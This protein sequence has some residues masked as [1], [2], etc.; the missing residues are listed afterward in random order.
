MLI[1][2]E[3]EMNITH[4]NIKYYLEKGYNCII[5]EKI[6]INIEDLNPNSHYQVEVQCNHCKT[7]KNM[8]YEVYLR[9]INNTEINEYYCVHCKSF[10]RERIAQIKQNQKL[11][12][13]GD[14]YYWFFEENRI[15]ELQKYID[16]YGNI[17]NV[18]INDS[19]LYNA[20][21]EYDGSSVLLAEKA[22][23]N[24]DSIMTN[25][26]YGYYDDLD[27]LVFE[28]QK[29]IDHYGRFPTQNEMSN[30][31]KFY[32][33]HIYKHFD[34]IDQLKIYMEYNDNNDLIDNRGDR[35]SS[36]YE[37]YVA[38]FLIAHGLKDLYKREQ[39]PF[40]KY[41]K[42]IFYRSDFTLYLQD[43]EDIHIEVWGENG[44]ETSPKY[45]NYNETMK[46]KMSL[47][48]KYSNNMRL[49]SI[50][51]K[52]LCGTYEQIYKNLFNIFKPYLNL[53]FKEIDYNLL[54]S[55]NDLKDYEVF[56]EI[57]K[58]SRDSDYLPTRRELQKDD[59]GIKL[60]NIVIS[61]YGGFIYF[62]NKFN[63]NMRSK[64]N[65][66]W[67][68]IEVYNRFDYMFDKYGRILSYEEYKNDKD[69]NLIGV[70]SYMQHNKGH[71]YYKLQYINYIIKN[72]RKI[73]DQMVE[74]LEDANNGR[75]NG[76]N[77]HT[78]DS[79]N[80]LITSVYN[81]F[82]SYQHHLKQSA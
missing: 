33:Y 66:Y 5:G 27:N 67:N 48:D 17:H 19:K 53:D 1:T 64:M 16:K 72:S 22:G 38:N 82:S 59:Y 50:F 51:P 43:G 25:K 13:R 45:Q 21:I 10:K 49:I 47:Y 15:F 44:D 71:I 26:P 58:Y 81:G 14:D 41:D 76:T 80:E 69:P 31:L 20:I 34:N 18:D 70:Y 30:E 54:I 56:D 35:N 62:F 32:H 9:N 74:F 55:N 57:M 42:N 52:H 75:I 23:L 78:V 73:P 37:L 28:I 61:K 29:F 79:F 46:T 40:K 39:Y 12:K 4:R 2:K 24:L 6:S 63:K 3:V 7:I 8:Q 68:E 11:L 36:Y 77:K 60:Y 65:N